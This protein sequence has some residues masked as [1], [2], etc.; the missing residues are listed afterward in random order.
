MEANYPQPSSITSSKLFKALLL[1]F[2]LQECNYYF[3]LFSLEEIKVI[4]VDVYF[5]Y[6]SGDVYVVLNS[7]T[8]QMTKQR[9]F[10]QY[11]EK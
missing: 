9:L 4:V 6:S 2:S 5:L 8:G 1:D 10:T 3:F 7:F 11:Q